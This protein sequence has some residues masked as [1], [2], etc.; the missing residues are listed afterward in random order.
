MD[1]SRYKLSLLASAGI[2]FGLTGCA[3]N[4]SI[5]V[6]II[7]NGTYSGS[8]TGASGDSGTMSFTVDSIGSITG[9]VTDTT[10]NQTGTMGTANIDNNGHFYVA[11]TIGSA[12]D[13]FQ[14]NVSLNSSNHMV[15]TI[16]ETGGQSQQVVV[17]FAKTQAAVR[18]S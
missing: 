1:I 10:V 7:Y 8:Y 14:G 13:V 12:S 16:T 17:D 11:V 6:P 15:G 5:A 18:R 9:T 2:A 3:G 4:G